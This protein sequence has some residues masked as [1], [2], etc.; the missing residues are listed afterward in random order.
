MTDSATPGQLLF[1]KLGIDLDEVPL[2]QLSDYTAVEYFLTVEDEPPPDSTNLEKV[3]RYTESLHHLCRMLFWKGIVSTFDF[4]ITINSTKESFSLPLSEYMI[5]KGMFIK[6]LEL[7]EDIINSLQQTITGSVLSYIKIIKARALGGTGNL[8]K[9][10]RIYEELCSEFPTNS[11]IY[12]E[13]K[14]RLAI[15]QVQR[16]HYQVGIKNLKELL[17]S[18][19]VFFDSERDSLSN[20]KILELKTDLLANLAYYEMNQGEFKQANYRYGEVLDLLEKHKLWHKIIYPMVHKGIILRKVFRAKE[21]IDSLKLARNKAIKIQDDNALF[22]ID[23]H[24]AWALRMDKKYKDAEEHCRRFL[25]GCREIGDDRGISD[26]YELLGFICLDKG[27]ISSAI[28]NLEKARNWRKSIDSTQGEASCVMGLAI[29]YLRRGNLL[30]FITNLLQGF[31]LYQK[32]GV[33]N[34][35][36]ISRIFAFAR[37]FRH[38]LLGVRVK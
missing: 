14:V 34:W 2:E 18:I 27:E 29:A 1:A 37:V 4:P 25:E 35:S 38:L 28:K 23:H 31:R 17:D 21:S 22:W 3:K 11:E 16:E 19:E 26:S 12:I 7:S 15:S 36:R 30:K 9:A 5:F 13:S 20:L 33:L 10:S 8:D 6:L 24:L 32:A